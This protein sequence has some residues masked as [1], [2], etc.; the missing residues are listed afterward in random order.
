[1]Y[2]GMDNYVAGRMCGELVKQALPKGGELLL[3]V[4]R[5]EQDNAKRRRQGVIDVLMGRDQFS[6]FDPVGEVIEG[7][8]YKILDTLTD[9]GD[10]DVAK[11]KAEDAITTYPE[12]DAFVGLFAYNPP[13]CLQALKSQNKIG[14]IQ[15]IGFDEDDLTLQGIKDGHI[16]GTV[17][18]DPYNYGYKSVEVLKSLVE[19]DHSVIPESKFIDIPA[20]SITKENVDSFWDTLKSRTGG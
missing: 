13:A 4:G 10:T 7:N 16:V 5:P 12:L 8:G 20:R 19:G 9:Q 17:V 15:V 11:R 1:M 3:T 14:Q 2:I 18:Q 6:Q